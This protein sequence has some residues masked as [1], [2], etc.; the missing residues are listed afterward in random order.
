[1]WN[2][3]WWIWWTLVELGAL[4]S[5]VAVIVAGEASWTGWDTGFGFAAWSLLGL[6]RWVWAGQLA[7][8]QRGSREWERLSR[9]WQKRAWDAYRQAHPG[10]PLPLLW[11]ACTLDNHPQE[12]TP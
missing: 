1:M 12:K 11:P 4:G 9:Q 8:A 10:Q 5:M 7:R 6:C 2:R 3:A